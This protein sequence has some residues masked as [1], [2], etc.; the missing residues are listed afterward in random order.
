MITRGV[1][2]TEMYGETFSLLIFEEQSKALFFS[3]GLR[4][5]PNTRHLNILKASA[6]RCDCAEKDAN[7][8]EEGLVISQRRFCLLFF[9]TG[10]LASSDVC[11]FTWNDKNRNKKNQRNVSVQTS[12]IVT[13]NPLALS[14]VTIKPTVQRLYGTI[15]RPREEVTD[16]ARTSENRHCTGTKWRKTESEVGEPGWCAVL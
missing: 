3:A 11:L 16:S 5:G 7:I 8:E 15:E 6:D 4:P 9:L 14:M 10:E 12:T 13:R 2:G 1:W